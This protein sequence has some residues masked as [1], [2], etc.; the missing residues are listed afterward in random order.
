MFGLNLS[1][2]PTIDWVAFVF[3]YLFISMR[4]YIF[5]QGLMLYFAAIYLNGV[6]Q[7]IIAKIHFYQSKRI[8]IQTQIAH[9]LYKHTQIYI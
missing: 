1:H 9:L 8:G 7:Y 3:G 2:N 5:D 6:G 4:D